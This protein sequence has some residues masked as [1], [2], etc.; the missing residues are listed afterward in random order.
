M[1]E[2]NPYL[3]APSGSRGGGRFIE[4]PAA[5]EN[6]VFQTRGEA[7]TGFEEQLAD[8]LMAAYAAGATELDEVVRALAGQ[9]CVDR[10]GAAWTEAALRAELAVLASLFVPAEARP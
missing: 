7:L 9:G 10:A 6:I 3:V 5:V 8:A 1:L 2:L 4:D